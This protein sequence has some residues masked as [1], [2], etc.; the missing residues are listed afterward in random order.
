MMLFLF[1]RL[2]G[3]M[4]M[5][6]ESQCSMGEANWICLSHLLMGHL[7]RMATD[8]GAE[9]W[10][11][12]LLSRCRP[13]SAWVFNQIAKRKRCFRCMREA[14][15]E[16]ISIS[17]GQKVKKQRW[18]DSLKERAAQVTSSLEDHYASEALIAF[19]KRLVKLPVESKSFLKQFVLKQSSTKVKYA[20]KWNE[21][22]YRRKNKQKNKD[23][24]LLAHYG[25]HQHM[26][27][28]K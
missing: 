6:A 13:V 25:S 1:L 16:L 7:Y 3:W 21:K 2:P 18:E 4:G 19:E 20:L 15:L 12:G 27:L 23:D 9:Q 22:R 14:G 10:F 5:N 28:S 24:Q 17:S 8:T 11:G 26:W